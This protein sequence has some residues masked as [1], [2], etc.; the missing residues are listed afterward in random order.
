M[1]S[2]YSR[3]GSGLLGLG[4]LVDTFENWGI[5]TK[6]GCLLT[7]TRAGV[8]I[9]GYLGGRYGFRVYTGRDE[10]YYV[11]QPPFISE[12]HTPGSWVHGYTGIGIW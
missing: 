7:G 8:G 6:D 4:L 11:C 1:V 5:Y 3:R 9:T 12:W 10:R 2:I